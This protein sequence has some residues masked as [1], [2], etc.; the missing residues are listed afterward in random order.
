MQFGPLF[1]M[2]P[3]NV[4]YFIF[5]GSMDNDRLNNLENLF[6]N[7]AENCIS[8]NNLF[9][10]EKQ[11]VEKQETEKTHSI[12]ERRDSIEERMV[13]EEEEDCKVKSGTWNILLIFIYGSFS[14]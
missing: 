4:N 7:S 3:V 6:K 1:N 10:I 8:H 11:G 13:D 5:Q 12:K 9:I 2:Q 14:S